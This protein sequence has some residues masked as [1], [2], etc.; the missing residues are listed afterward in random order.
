M[1]DLDV[2][3]AAMAVSVCLRETPKSLT[4]LVFQTGLPSPL[5]SRALRLL[6]ASCGCRWIPGRGFVYWSPEA[7]EEFLSAIVEDACRSLLDGFD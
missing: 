1:T 3:R 4:W 5:V 6:T 7:E 2:S